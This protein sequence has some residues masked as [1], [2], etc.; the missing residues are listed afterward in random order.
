MVNFCFGV[1]VTR[2]QSGL[3]G[4]VNIT[5]DPKMDKGDCIFFYEES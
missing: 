1:Q 4:K 3:R 2:C 5:Q